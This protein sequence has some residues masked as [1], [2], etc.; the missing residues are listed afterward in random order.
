MILLDTDVCLALLA[1]NKKILELYG[2]AT[3]EIGIPAPCVQE[4]FFAAGKSEDPDRNSELIETLLLTV[5][6]VHPDIQVL[7][8]ASEI[9]RK[10]TQER[11]PCSYIDLLLYSMSKVLGARLV[12][13][14]GKRYMFHVKQ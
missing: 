5:T 4:L 6:I 11:R 3:E 2:D 12:T 10:Y 14:H 7:R 1:G 9:Q 13:A 8:Y